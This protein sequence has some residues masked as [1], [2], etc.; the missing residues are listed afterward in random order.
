MYSSQAMPMAMSGSVQA[1]STGA[2]VRKLK[3]VCS[4]LL[5][6][7]GSGADTLVNVLVGTDD[8]FLTG[9]GN[10]TI[11][12]GGGNDLIDAGEG[13]DSIDAGAGDDLRPEGIRPVQG[14]DLVV[15]ENRPGGDD[16]V[17]EVVKVPPHFFAEPGDKGVDHGLQRGRL[18]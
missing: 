11:R 15:Q 18:S 13:D 9:V 7:T 16:P 14:D 4:Q 2:I 3:P 1:I 6:S 17:I 8:T 10:D 5:L 12:A